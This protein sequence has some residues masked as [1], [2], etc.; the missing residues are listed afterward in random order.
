MKKKFLLLVVF[1]CVCIITAQSQQW[2][3][4]T[5]YSLQNSNS[6]ALIDTNGTTF[7]TWTFSNA[8]T[9]Y[10]S[11][12]THG[13]DIWRAVAK[14]GNSFTGG[15]MTGRLTKHSYS[16]TL[17]WDYTCSTTSYCSHHDICPMPN[18]NVLIIA[19]ESKSAAEVTAAGCSQNIIIWSEKIIEVQPT[20]ATTG[21]IV[22]EWH[23]WDH[24]VQNYDPTKANYQTSILN[25]PQLVNINY[26]TQKD[27]IHMNGIDYNPI[28]DQIVVS[29]HNLN[30][31]WVIDH[32]T[33]TAE[34]AGHT[35]GLAGKGGDI[36]YRWGN[37]LAYQASGTK[38]FNVVHDAHWIPEDSPNAGRLVGFNNKGVSNSQSSVD[39]I[40]PPLNGYN[41]DIVLGNAYTPSTYS[42]R[43]SCNGV[44]QNESSSEQLPNGNTLVCLFQSGL[45]YETDPQGTTIWSKTLS[46][47]NSQAHRYTSCYINNLPPDIPVISENNN[48]LYST[49][50]D[51]YQ[52]YLNGVQ[53]PNATGQS[54][55]PTQSGAYLVRIQD[56]QNCFSR[57]S[58]THVFSYTV[59]IK[60]PNVQPTVSKIY[61]NPNNGSFEISLNN[62]VNYLCKIYDMLGTTIFSEFQPAS[63]NLQWNPEGMYFVSIITENGIIENHKLIIQK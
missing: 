31:L 35:G 29:S 49:A 11:Y 53:I 17:L 22:W 39:Q 23:L 45:I 63:V 44:S 21:N 42:H 47:Q 13:G 4:Y 8:P 19:Y 48:I 41:Y 7:K 38:I 28:L 33:T 57:Y 56:A 9:G 12:L 30:E 40:L 36:L 55:T 15:G 25:N 58:K 26:L 59:N 24:L 52:W 60:E 37:P 61:P 34:A 2:D 20:G 6:A 43:L 32:S 51:S 62:Q 3:G 54:Y 16:G 46:G 5:L 50:A 10:S 18:G 27:W 14:T 1:I